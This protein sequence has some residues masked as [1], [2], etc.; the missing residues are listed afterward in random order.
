MDERW[1]HQRTRYR[2]LEAA[3]GGVERPTEP[4]VAVKFY[5][6]DCFPPT[7]ENRGFVRDHVRELTKTSRVV[8]LTTGLNLDDHGG[9]GDPAHERA[10]A[11]TL[12]P[13]ELHPRDNLAVQSRIVAGASA[14]VGTYGGFSYL[15]P[16]LG[17]QST[18]YFGDADGFSKRHLLMARSAL[19]VLGAGHLFMVQPTRGEPLA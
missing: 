13:A 1:V 10:A 17:V 8:S 2:H 9:E 11:V 14:F 15:A 4:Y 3:C 7:D 18:A 16:F 12:L 5:F 19:D 6:N